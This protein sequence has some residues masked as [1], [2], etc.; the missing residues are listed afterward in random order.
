[1]PDKKIE[2]LPLNGRSY[3]DLLGLQ[4]EVAPVANPSPFQPRQVVSGDLTSGELAVNGQRENANEFMVNGAIAEDH[5]S[6][7]ASVIPVLDSI[8]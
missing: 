4:T 5:G 8:Q 6:N 1:M 3:L 7:G 2:A